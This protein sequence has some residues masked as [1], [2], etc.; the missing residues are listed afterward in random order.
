MTE[1][2][3]NQPENRTKTAR[4]RPNCGT[5][6]APNIGA[7]GREIAA[8][9][10]LPYNKKRTQTPIK[11]GTP[12]ECDTLATRDVLLDIAIFRWAKGSGRAFHRYNVGAW[13]V[14]KFMFEPVTLLQIIEIRA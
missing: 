1:N 5:I 2:A 14:Y 7:G 4:T 8:F 6:Y 10:L 13:T 3:P 9:I 11:T 12:P